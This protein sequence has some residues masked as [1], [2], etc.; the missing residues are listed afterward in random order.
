M[1]EQTITPMPSTKPPNDKLFKILLLVIG[2]LIVIGLFLN[3]FLLLKKQ[4]PVKPA[5]IP[6]TSIPTQVVTSPT[7]TPDET[8]NWKIYRNEKYGFEFKYPEDYLISDKPFK[9]STETDNNFL[10][11]RISLIQ[12]KNYKVGQPPTI[13]LGILDT[14][15]SISEFIEEDYQREVKDWEEWKKASGSETD[16][17]LINSIKE[18][19]S[20]FITATK[21]ERERISTA[22]NS[23]ET[24]YLFKK[25][26]FLYI[27]SVNYGTFNPDTGEDGTTEKA[28]L[29]LMFS[30]FKF[31]P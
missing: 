7:S 12:K 24:Q 29:E 16:K 2:L 1:E 19:K 9:V 30:S 26:N 6:P 8:A 25:N 3:A 22:P 15:K 31:L 17:P 18:V 20:N 14:Q 23:K 5:E 11:Q 10:S 27:F 28:T 21:V 13:Y 4:K